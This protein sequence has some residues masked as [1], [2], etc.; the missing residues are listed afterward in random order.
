MP[1]DREEADGAGGVIERPRDG[2]AICV[3]SVTE[4]TKTDRVDAHDATL[5]DVHPLEYVYAFRL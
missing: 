2:E 4:R 3:G 5:P 1:G